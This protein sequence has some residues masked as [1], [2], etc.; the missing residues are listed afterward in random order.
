MSTAI[1]VIDNGKRIR[2]PDPRIRGMGFVV[3]YNDRPYGKDRG[4]GIIHRYDM[5]CPL[6]PADCMQDDHFAMFSVFDVQE[7]EG[8]PEEGDEME[9]VAIPYHKGGMAV[10]TD[11][12]FSWR[13]DKKT[14]VEELR[15]RYRSS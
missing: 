12:R 5:Q 10:I 9:F 7:L 2:L 4:R 6:A 1:A 14:S 13:G 3:F 8:I 15:A 11:L